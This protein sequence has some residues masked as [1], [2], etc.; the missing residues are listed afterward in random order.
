MTATHLDS[1]AIATHIVGGLKNADYP[2]PSG[3]ST[4][5]ALVMNARGKLTVRALAAVA[6]IG[7]VPALAAHA[8][9]AA[10][11]HTSCRALGATTA[12]EAR[13]HAVAPEILAFAPGSVDDLIALVQLGGT[14][15]AEIVE[16]LCVPK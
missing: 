8:A 5:V 1:E 7:L 12:A 3:R 16:G 6:V 9:S 10:P 4:D 13:D 14:F 11:G 15:E 2:P